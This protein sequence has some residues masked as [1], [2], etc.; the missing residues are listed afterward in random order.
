MDNNEKV[1]TKYIYK[2]ISIKT[3]LEEVHLNKMG[4]KGWRLVSIIKESDSL[5]AY[6]FVKEEIQCLYLNDGEIFELENK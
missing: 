1:Y 3:L 2:K 6:Y 4:E 5:Y